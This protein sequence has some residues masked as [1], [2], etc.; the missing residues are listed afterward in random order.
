LTKGSA[1]VTSW[2]WFVQDQVYSGNLATHSFKDSGSYF[3]ELKVENDNGCRDSVT[4]TIYVNADLFVHVPTGFSPNGDGKNDLFGLEGLTQGV[5]QYKM[6]IYDRWGA[7]IF[8]SDNVN[9]KW[10][11]TY[12]GEPVPPGMYVYMVQYTNPRQTKWFYQKDV[13]HLIK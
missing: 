4:K 2:N 11:G 7:L 10:D 12:Q 3:V 8:K 5:F 1:D 6:E 13:V 9:D